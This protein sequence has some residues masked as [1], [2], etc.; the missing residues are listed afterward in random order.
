MLNVKKVIVVDMIHSRCALMI[1][2][3]HLGLDL[4]YRVQFR[5]K[6]SRRPKTKTAHE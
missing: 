4:Y 5:E 1:S 6:I 2:E 3:F